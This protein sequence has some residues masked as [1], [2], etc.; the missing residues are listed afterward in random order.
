ML[1]GDDGGIIDPSL[2]S[3]PELE[4]RRPSKLSLDGCIPYD[5]DLEGMN[6]VELSVVDSASLSMI[7]QSLYIT[8][9]V[10]CCRTTDR[11]C[12]GVSTPC[13]MVRLLYLL[14]RN[15]LRSLFRACETGMS[16]AVMQA[17]A[18]T[19]ASGCRSVVFPLP[20]KDSGNPVS[21]SRR[22]DTG[23]GLSE[24][25]P[26]VSQLD[27]LSRVDLFDDLNRQLGQRCWS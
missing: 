13:E 9:A 24:M 14:P 8:E 7:A 20:Q 3:C 4:L 19:L 23:L 21:H 12:C 27:Q 6:G 11:C 2:E 15:D 22:V 1:E 18:P 10:F 26:I 25:I 17:S 5:A 16:S